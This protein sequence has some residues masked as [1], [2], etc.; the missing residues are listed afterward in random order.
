M[1]PAL[2]TAGWGVVERGRILREYQISPGRI[3]GRGW[4]GLPEIADYVLV[5]RNINPVVVEAKAWEK[6]KWSALWS[7]EGS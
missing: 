2:K 6:A 1:D 7:H 3:K 5:F 4:R